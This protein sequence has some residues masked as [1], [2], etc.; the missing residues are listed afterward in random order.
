[1]KYL[2]LRAMLSSVYFKGI[3]SYKVNQT[4]LSPKEPRTIHFDKDIAVPLHK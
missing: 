1:M 4:K 3:R 2:Y